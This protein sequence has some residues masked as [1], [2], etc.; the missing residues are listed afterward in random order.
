MYKAILLKL[1]DK[2]KKEVSEKADGIAA[3]DRLEDMNGY[4]SIADTRL[5]DK[6][7]N[8]AVAY[9]TIVDFLTSEFEDVGEYKKGVIVSMVQDKTT[10]KDEE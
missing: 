9:I 10:R 2:L 8:M 6:L 5:R 7:E 1:L 4:L 3:L